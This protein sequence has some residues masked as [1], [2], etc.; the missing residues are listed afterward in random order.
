VCSSDLQYLGNAKILPT[1]PDIIGAST[2]DQGALLLKQA[3]EKG[4]KGQ[5]A[6]PYAA[7]KSWIKTGGEQ[8]M[9]GTL[10]IGVDATS[11][12]VPKG[13]RDFHA[14]YVKKYGEE[15]G[16]WSDWLT[17][18]PYVIA[19]ALAKAGTIDDVEKIKAV[20][21]KELFKTPWGEIGYGGAK[22]FGVPHQLLIPIFISTVKN[23]KIM[24]L[25]RIDGAEIEKLMS[26]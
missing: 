20:L 25:D 12:L 19:Q 8:N 23:G 7:S 9:E 6:T 22:K 1:N 11:E 3:R 18:P 24:V 15:P 10:N 2:G 4:Y 26:E 13:V 5:F 14:A 21:E 17:T 16:A